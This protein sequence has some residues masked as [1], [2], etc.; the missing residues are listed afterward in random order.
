MVSRRQGGR[1]GNVAEQILD[2]LN[3]NQREAVTAIDGPLLIVAGPG[4]GKTRVITHRI[5]YLVRVVGIAPYRIAAVTFTN[6]A[7]REMRQRLFPLLGQAAE[8]LTASTFHAFCANVLRREGEHIGL[9]RDFVIY[10]DADQMALVKRALIELELDPKRFPPRSILSGISGAKSELLGPDGLAHRS[11]SYWDE[12]IV[13]TYERYEDLLRQCSAVDFDDL[14]LRTYQLFERVPDV[15]RKYQERYVHFMVD[16]FQDT[17]IAQYAIAKQ[18][19]RYHLNICVVGD[20]DQSIY[21]WRNADIR[22]ILSFQNDYP[23]AKLIALEENYRSTQTILDAA[24]SLIASNTQRVEKDLWTRNG[25]GVPIT[26]AEGYDEEEEAQFVIREIQHLTR[27]SEA[28]VGRKPSGV[29]LGDIAVMYRVNAQS[30]A[31]EEACL[32]Y[33]VPYQVVGGMKFYQRQEVKD[34]IAYL[35]LIANPD[36]DVSLNRVINLPTRGIGQR[37]LDHLARTA[38]DAGTS[39]FT[40]IQSLSGDEQRDQ[41]MPADALSGES[42]AMQS[43]AISPFTARAKTA[44][45]AFGNIVGG[46]AAERDNMDLLDIIDAVLERSG[47]QRWLLSQERGEERMENIQEFRASARE[48][49]YVGREEA[50]TAFLESVSLVADVDSMEERADAI[51]LIT[52]HQAKG[53]EFP[54]VFMVGMEEGLL[55][56]SRSVDDPTQLEEERRLC[57]V[58]V[59]R[60]KERLYL[61]RA[62]RRGFRGGS[63]PGMP[64]RFLLDIPQELQAAPSQPKRPGAGNRGSTSRRARTPNGTQTSLAASDERR[65]E[66]TGRS[67]NATTPSAG[68]RQSG[69]QRVSG[70]RT[71]AQRSTNPTP[72][73]RFGRAPS[74]PGQRPIRGGNTAP[75]SPHLT[76]GDKVMHKVFGEGIVTECKPTGNDF[77]VTVAFRDGAG[78]KR[79][80]LGMAPIEK[81]D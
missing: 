51:T 40:V 59:T 43:P 76:T 27:N 52:L 29:G 49:L 62:F 67:Q 78:I 8:Q 70:K 36:D 15:A 18:L 9:D 33:G 28:V 45:I 22:N 77:E 35:R 50:L 42:I 48:F 34:I 79:L 54:V 26:I 47:Y 37:T 19:S 17:N 61:L 6:K 16:E 65:R 44:L 41:A 56:H 2:G 58:G 5:A 24:R 10:D 68:T 69:N 25:E 39:Q 72:T 11:D 31:L 57:Y 53:L 75:S 46:I 60:A 1:V 13:R 71:T 66:S 14:I 80:L 38:R 73:R 32:R 55:P 64:S 81:L 7:A 74:V 4:S 3:D 23:K 63:E 20:P 12:I 30:R 21:T